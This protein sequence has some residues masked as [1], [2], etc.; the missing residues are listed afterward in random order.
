MSFRILPIF[1]RDKE[2]ETLELFKKHIKKVQETR[3]AFHEAAEALFKSNFND[4]NQKVE[5]VNIK[6]R[7]TDDIRREVILCLFEGAFLPVTRSR[8]YE[9]SE[10]IDNVADEIQDAADMLV[11]FKGRKLPK[12]IMNLIKEIVKE[13][14]E[15]VDELEN[16]FNDLLDNREISSDFKKMKITEE[17]ADILQQQLLKK[18]YFNKKIDPVT[19]SI[20]AR[21]GHIISKISNEVE[22]SF[23]K[24]SIIKLLKLA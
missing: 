22:S 5:I 8:L 17:K 23:N 4:V 11:F 16:G 9:L 1:G 6:E 20:V 12:D 14:E 10:S 18:L 15:S 13:A 24:M 7:E 21:T 3:K 2:K 19:V